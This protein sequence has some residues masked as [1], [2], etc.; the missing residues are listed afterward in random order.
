MNSASSISSRASIG[1]SS[2]LFFD[3]AFGA[4]AMFFAVQYGFGQSKEGSLRRSS[5]MVFFNFVL[6]PPQSVLMIRAFHDPLDL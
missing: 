4:N 6:C 5:A 1:I 3:S 2:D